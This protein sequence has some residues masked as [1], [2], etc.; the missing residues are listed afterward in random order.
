MASSHTS[1]VRECVLTIL[2]L[3]YVMTDMK[4]MPPNL[5]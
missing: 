5:K 3:E 4:K 1:E 2:I